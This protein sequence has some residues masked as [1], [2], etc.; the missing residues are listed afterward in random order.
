L[1]EPATEQTQDV[2]M[3]QK[4]A[5]SLSMFIR[6]TLLTAMA[7]SAIAIAGCQNG[8]PPTASAATA[9]QQA[10]VVRGNGGSVTVF[11]PGDDPNKP[12][13]LT[14]AGSEVCPECEAAA[15]KYFKTGVLDPKCSRTGATR[16]AVT[17]TPSTTGHQ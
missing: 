17:L 1:N 8:T 5:R 12:M 13:A 14:G 6:R 15:A 9:P 4:F 3:P 16:T 10:I 11:V 7:L 2:I